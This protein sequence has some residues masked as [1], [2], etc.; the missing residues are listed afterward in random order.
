MDHQLTVGAVQKRREVSWHG[1]L[2]HEKEENTGQCGNLLWKAQNLG[3]S[4]QGVS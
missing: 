1:E 3:D 2:R 4:E